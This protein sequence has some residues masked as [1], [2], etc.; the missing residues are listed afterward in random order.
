MNNKGLILTLLGILTS[1]TLAVAQHQTFEVLA[2]EY[3]PFTTP[4][5]PKGGLAFE[6]LENA[7]QDVTW[8]PLFV[9]PRRAYAII[10]SGHWCASFYPSH[11]PQTHISIELSDQPI[12]IG[13]VRQKQPGK[14]SW[15]DL[16][17]FTGKSVALLRTKDSSAFVQQF[18]QAGLRPVFVE[19]VQ[20]GLQMV[21]LNR[22]DMAMLDDTSFAALSQSDKAK[23]QIS[24]K[25]LL[26]TPITLYVNR[27][28]LDVFPSID[29]KDS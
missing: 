15:A 8:K 14:F 6:L 21:L 10:D 24:A 19:S 16:N 5:H 20:A 13:L 1:T 17:E 26:E 23:L 22:V 28:C 29:F 2:V 18:Q 3:P 7:N 9:P 25:W 12:K 11:K 27:A 4:A